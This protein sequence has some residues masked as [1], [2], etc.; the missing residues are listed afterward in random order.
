[1]L[2]QHEGIVPHQRVAS[3][4]EHDPQ[5]RETRGHGQQGDQRISER[6]PGRE[7]R[8]REP[9]NEAEQADAQTKSHEEPT[10][11]HA[12]PGEMAS[13]EEDEDAAEVRR[14]ADR[15]STRLNSSHSQIS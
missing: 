7:N 10:S 12:P 6:L 14:E 4:S 8:A 15:K 3:D 2:L 1:M 13:A 9:T 11:A 5:S